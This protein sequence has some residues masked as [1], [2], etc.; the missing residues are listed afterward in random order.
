MVYINQYKSGLANILI[1][2]EDIVALA[3][4]EVGSND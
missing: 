2:F 3:Q 1:A 4:V